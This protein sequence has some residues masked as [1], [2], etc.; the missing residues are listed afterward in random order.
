MKLAKAAHTAA[1]FEKAKLYYQTGIE[2]LLEM[3]E[4]EKDEL[5][6][7]SAYTNLTSCLTMLHQYPEAEREIPCLG[8]PN[9]D[10]DPTDPGWHTP[11]ISRRQINKNDRGRKILC[12]FA[13][14]RD[15]IPGTGE[16]QGNTILPPVT[17]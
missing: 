10:N 5:I 14:L 7:G 11:G 6:L 8:V 15:I 1:Q 3:P 4:N 2:C 9:P 16:K 17:V 12:H 13:I